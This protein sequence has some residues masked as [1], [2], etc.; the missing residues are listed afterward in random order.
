M[1]DMTHDTLFPLGKIF[2]VRHKRNGKNVTMV[3]Q[4]Q[5]RLHEAANEIRGEETEE[6][7][8]DQLEWQLA[9]GIRPFQ[10]NRPLSGL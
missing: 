5:K 7:D 6:P 4:L 3:S 10:E 2:Y 8:L 1:N 9:A